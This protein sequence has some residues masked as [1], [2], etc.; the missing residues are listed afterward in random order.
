MKGCVE[1]NLLKDYAASRTSFE[2]ALAIDPNYIDANVNMAYTYMNEVVSRRN[3]GEFKLDRTNVKQFNEEF[4]KIKVYYEK[5]L[6]YF[7]K[8]RE[9]APD[10]PRLWASALQ[11]IYTNLQQPDKAKEMDA[12]IES[13]NANAKQ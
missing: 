7:E 9:L 4:E 13:S 1:L 8:V 10:Q 2:K 5:A 3:K 6:P 12:Y 11:Q